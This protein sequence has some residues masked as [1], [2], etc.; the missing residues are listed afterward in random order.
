MENERGWERRDGGEETSAILETKRLYLREMRPSDYDALCR[1]L[2]D[3]ETMRAA[4]D[5]AFTGEEARGWLDRQMARYRQLGFGLWAV[6]RKDTGEMIGQ[7][8]LTWQPW[9]D[10][11]VLEIGYLFQRAHWGRGYATEAARACKRYAFTALDADEVHSLI[12]D[13]HVASQRVAERNGMRIADRCVKRFRDADMRFYDYVVKRS[14]GD[15]PT[16]D[17]RP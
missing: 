1:I 6:V 17:S 12:R 5:G 8:G 7:C 11:Q 9:R 15:R 4:Y 2:C 10:R 13:T 14:S 3:E 16:G